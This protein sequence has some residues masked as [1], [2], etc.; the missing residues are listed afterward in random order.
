MQLV[1]YILFVVIKTNN[2]RLRR[3]IFTMKTLRTWLDACITS[4]ANIEI[5]RHT[6]AHVF[7]DTYVGYSDRERDRINACQENV[8]LQNSD[9]PLHL[10]LHLLFLQDL[11]KPSET[12]PLALTGIK[13][14]IG[15]ILHQTTKQQ[16][17]YTMGH[18]NF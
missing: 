16:E 15:N 5:H 12:R 3:N 10:F 4:E 9:G 13:I 7:T 14:L 11:A 2:S 17:K 6:N 18:F 1:A 8:V